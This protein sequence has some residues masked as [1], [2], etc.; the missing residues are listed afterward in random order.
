MRHRI[1]TGVTFAVVGVLLLLD[2]W[3]AVDLPAGA[4][5]AVLLLGLGSSLIVGH[6]KP[7]EPA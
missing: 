5:P 1:V 7:D 4:V 6:G 3:G 2:A